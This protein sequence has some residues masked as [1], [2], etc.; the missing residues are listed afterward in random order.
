MQKGKLET[1]R[2][3]CSNIDSRLIFKRCSYF[4]HLFHV[5]LHYH[6]IDAVFLFMKACVVLSKTFKCLYSRRNPKNYYSTKRFLEDIFMWRVHSF[7]SQVHNIF[8]CSALFIFPFK[9]WIAKFISYAKCLHS[10]LNFIPIY[11]LN[12]LL[13]CLCKNI[14]W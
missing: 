9:E 8:D 2:L 13:V 5:V 6:S 14:F 12:W 11:L 7:L 10:T 3:E 4:V 1:L